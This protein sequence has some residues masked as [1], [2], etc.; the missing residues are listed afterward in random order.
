MALFNC[1]IIDNW[2]NIAILIFAGLSACFAGWAAW[3]S[4]L[5]Y[6]R[7]NPKIKVNVSVGLAVYTGRGCV[8]SIN[9]EI[10]NHGR[11]FVVIN[12]IFF[13][14]RD[15]RSLVFDCNVADI[16]LS[17]ERSLPAVLEEGT[18]FMIIFNLFEL[19]KDLKSQNAKIKYLCFSDETGKKYLFQFKKRKWSLL[20]E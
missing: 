2:D 14:L 5:S 10:V 13:I 7:D 20:Y 15:G 1:T 12:N 4:F 19:K 8:D 9:C 11:R 3:L 6:K 16:I 18:K 17:I